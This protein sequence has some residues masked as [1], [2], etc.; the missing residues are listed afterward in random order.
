[1]TFSND[2]SKTE[3]GNINLELKFRH[4]KQNNYIF[5]KICLD[6]YTMRSLLGTIFIQFNLIF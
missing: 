4:K 2:G 5:R 3:P 6:E 1:V